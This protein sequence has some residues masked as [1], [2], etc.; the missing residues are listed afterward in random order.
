MAQVTAGADIAARAQAFGVP[1]AQVDGNDL[2]AVH[3][4]AVIAVARAREGRG[5]TLLECR[6]YRHYGHSKGDP[7][8]YRPRDEVERWMAHDPLTVAREHL[9]AD[10]VAA[11]RLDEVEQSAQERVDAASAAALDAAYPDPAHVAG[12]EFAA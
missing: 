12:T 7:A 2:W 8:T 9:L 10:G 1:S 5:P 3:E 11:E 4:A 6:T